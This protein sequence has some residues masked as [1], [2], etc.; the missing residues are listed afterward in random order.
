MRP[1]KPHRYEEVALTRHIIFFV[2]QGDRIIVYLEAFATRM[3]LA[4][5]EDLLTATSLKS[6]LYPET[7]LETPFMTLLASFLKAVLA[8]PDF[9]TLDLVRTMVEPSEVRPTVFLFAIPENLKE[10][11]LV[12]LPGSALKTVLLMPFLR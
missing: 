6:V 9:L 4:R 3:L 7:S 1:G 2:I 11:L 10:C 12:R 8:L 5:A